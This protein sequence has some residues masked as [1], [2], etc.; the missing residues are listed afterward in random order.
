[1]PLY[2][3]FNIMSH[4][5]L[6]AGVNFTFVA[7]LANFNSWYYPQKYLLPRVFNGGVCNN[8]FI[9]HLL[10]IRGEKNYDEGGKK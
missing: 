7:N 5:A 10:R 8:S 1:M 9:V 4:L 3:V 2:S 6:P